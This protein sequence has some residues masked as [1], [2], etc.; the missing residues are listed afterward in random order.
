MATAWPR[1]TRDENSPV[2]AHWFE[3]FDEPWKGIDDGWGLFDVD[4]HPKFAVSCSYPELVPS[5]PT[6]YAPTDAIFFQ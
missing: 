5:G 6:E 4:R 2:A 3:A 1:L